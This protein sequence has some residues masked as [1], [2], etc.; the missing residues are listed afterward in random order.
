MPPPPRRNNPPRQPFAGARPGA[1]PAGMQA[2][3]Q[4]FALFNQGRFGQAKRALQILIDKP[5]SRQAEQKAH[6]L[7]GACLVREARFD[8][9]AEHLRRAALMAPTD[10]QAK[11]DLAQSLQFANRLEEADQA[12]RSALAINPNHPESLAL[13]AAIRQGKGEHEAAVEILD[14]AR[15]RGVEHPAL[16]IA[17]AGSAARVGRESEAIEAL[18]RYAHDQ[19]VP[20]PHRQEILFQIASLLDK[21]KRY[22]EAFTKL[23][24]ANKAVPARYDASVDE[25][26]TDEIIEAWTAQ[27]LRAMPPGRDTSRK[28]TFIVGMPRSGTTLVENILDAHPD[29]HAAGELMLIP[30]IYTAHFPKGKPLADQ[31]KRFSERDAAAASSQYLSALDAIAPDARFVIDKRPHNF[32]YLGFMA[33]LFPGA[34]FIHTTRDPRDIGLSCYFRNFLHAFAWTTDLRWI[35]SFYAVYARLMHHWERVIPESGLPFEMIELRYEEVLA[36]QESASRRLLDFLG[37]DWT[38]EVLRFHERNRP[39]RTLLVDQV[40]LPVY[41]TSR[42]K[43]RR[44]EKHLKPLLDD[45][46]PWL[47][48]EERTPPPASP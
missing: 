33:L 9:G 28:P 34:R 22:D 47:P 6:H 10:V 42:A 17:L 23:E 27:R 39:A 43:W 26:Y 19:R 7:M 32:I 14:A 21:L 30:N 3:Q 38:D 45:L 48:D 40:G 44:Y 35:A 24:E 8:E 5:P 4:A 12:V 25:R 37:L 46:A 29:I 41:T 20:P 31:L 13:Q 11:Y 15:A 2:V 16:A 18:E 36:D 1:T